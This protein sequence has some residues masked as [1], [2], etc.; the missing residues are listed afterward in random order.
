MTTAISGNTV[1]VHYV[2]TFD[3]GEIFDSSR[4][5]GEPI[6]FQL[7]SNQ[8]VPGFESA[9]LG[10][11]EG[12]TKSVTLEPE[13][14][15]GPIQE[16]MTTLAPLSAFPEGSGADLVVGSAVYGTNQNGEQM[17]AII[18]E[19]DE[20]GVTLDFNHPLAGK[21]LTFKIELVNIQS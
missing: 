9:I 19:I 1:S 14:A 5:R 7:G 8:V 6:T 4:T 3:D 12:E 17:T 10:M 16:D 15:Y 11:S 21:S 13:D 2:G 18:K 20:S